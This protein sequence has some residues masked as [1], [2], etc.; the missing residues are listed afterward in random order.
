M[1]IIFSATGSF[2]CKMKKKKKKAIP[3]KIKNLPEDNY[4]ECTNGDRFIRL[5]AYS[6]RRLR[7]EHLLVFRCR[8]YVFMYI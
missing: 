6:Y 5:R 8:N 4:D 1:I 3:T 7:T 2:K